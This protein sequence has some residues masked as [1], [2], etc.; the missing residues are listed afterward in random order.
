MAPRNRP[1]PKP[2]PR[3]VSLREDVVYGAAPHRVDRERGIVYG[4]K[5]LGRRSVNGREYTAEAV[6]NAMSMYEGIGVNTNHPAKAGERRDVNDRFGWLAD[7]RIDEAG[8]LYGDLHVLLP[9]SE[10][11]QKVFAA[12]EQKPDL[13]GL[14]H[15]AQGDGETVDG[16][17]VVR[18]IVEVRS[19]DIVDEGA[20]TNSLFEGRRNVP[21]I[22]IKTLL[23]SLL[24]KFKGVPRRTLV[25]LL[26]M[27]DLIEPNAE[28]DEPVPP[29]GEGGEAGAD[30]D[31]EDHLHAGFSAA[32]H[33]I[34]DDDKMSAEDKIA[35]LKELLKG[36]DK[37]LGKGGAE[38]EGG[39][40]EETEEE[41]CEEED[42]EEEDKEKDKGGMKESKQVL[43]RRVR[44]YE[45]KDRA[46]E[47]CEAANVP[48][49]SILL[50]AL[51]KLDEDGMA[52]LIAREKARPAA[53]TNPPR[54]NKPG[55][56][57]TAAAPLQ[58]G[59][60]PGTDDLEQTAT[61]LR[62]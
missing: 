2:A 22:K 50:E 58:E 11:A 14:S 27:D 61:F 44:R 28:M 43:A 46:R 13:F 17:F 55:G 49:D 20:T 25:R 30:M 41:S 35:K 42:D 7:V 56:S 45:R 60:V 5:I 18:E 15:N 57:G 29:P 26:E 54:T 16:I 31:H 34:I 59:Q 40:E 8:E 39:E 47:L 38:G 9:G 62:N 33:A 23:E 6:R 37:M 52:K 1:R 12:A 21:R 53:A 10:F 36:E 24:P 48:C 51:S 32:C 3:R 19:V 4:V